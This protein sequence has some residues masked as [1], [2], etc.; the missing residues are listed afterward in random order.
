MVYIS[1]VFVEPHEIK[2]QLFADIWATTAT[3]SSCAKFGPNN[4]L[5]TTT[6]WNAFE[7]NFQ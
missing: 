4:Y 1:K 6:H 5:A 7:S 2:L 3:T